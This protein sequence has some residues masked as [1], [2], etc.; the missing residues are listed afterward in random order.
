MSLSGW[1]DNGW[2]V[3]HRPSAQEIGDLFAVAARDLKDSGVAALSQDTRLALAY[4]A[5][6]CVRPDGSF[7]EAQWQAFRSQAQGDVVQD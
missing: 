1:R 7:A 3:E 5:A 2:L 6:Q 4:N